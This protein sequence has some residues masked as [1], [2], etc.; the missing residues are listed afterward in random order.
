MINEI[1]P[2]D[3]EDDFYGSNNP[4]EY[5]EA[6]LALF[7]KA[8]VPADT[9]ADITAKGIY[10]TNAVKTPKWS[11]TVEKSMIEKSVPALAEEIELFPQLEVVMLM[12]DV[13]KKAFNM[14][15]RQKTGKNVVPAVS[16]Y[17]LRNTELF[18]RFDSRVI[19][20]LPSYIMTGGN[21]LIEKS[22]VEMAAEDVR[23]MMAVITREEF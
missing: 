2:P 19:R 18:Y 10:L 5:A 12:G 20:V 14:I 16:T 6:A 8:G 4:A 13:A 1:V 21:I 7:R 9:V 17:K 3:P 15:A 23:K 11:Y 22:K